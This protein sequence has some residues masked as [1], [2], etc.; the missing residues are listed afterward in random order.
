VRAFSTS[1]HRST[2]SACLPVRGAGPFGGAV[3]DRYSRR[4]VLLA[5]DAVRML[6]MAAIA[7]TVA[8]A[9]NGVGGCSEPLS[10]ETI[11]TIA[12]KRG[13]FSHSGFVSF[14]QPM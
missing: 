2:G 5:G 14:S 3:A 13:D 10:G 4:T 1:T 9:A 11:A 7:A 6:L 12:W 8:S